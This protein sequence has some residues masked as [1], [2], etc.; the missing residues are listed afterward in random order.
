MTMNF[1]HLRVSDLQ[2]PTAQR[3]H[4]AYSTS[5][6]VDN[7]L[8]GYVAAVLEAIP[9]TQVHYVGSRDAA[10]YRPGDVFA[11]GYIGY[12]DP[13][14]K[15]TTA[16]Q[17]HTPKYYVRA[18]GIANTKYKEHTWQHTG[19]FSSTL[20]AAVKTA[21]A[22]LR[23]YTAMDSLKVSQPQAKHVLDEALAASRR[24]WTGAYRRL[25]GT[26]HY[27]GDLPSAFWQIVRHTQL[28]D[29]ELEKARDEMFS[30][31]DEYRRIE[32]MVNGAMRYIELRDNYGQLIADGVDLSSVT[33]SGSTTLIRPV[34]VE[35]LPEDTA[36]AI[37]VLRMVAP[38]HY[39]AGIGFRLDDR[40]FYLHRMGE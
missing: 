33:S 26:T 22:W 5:P 2:E 17:Q 8:R 19:Q 21:Q 3:D 14:I 1:T 20:R 32:A 30:G 29:V 28:H 13:R 25:T 9:G 38:A 40:S 34:P 27:G 15:R 7:E 24:E 11:L 4:N 37:A 39:V 23:P 16:H 10:I 31:Y 18:R 6:Y 36:G 35:N 12:D